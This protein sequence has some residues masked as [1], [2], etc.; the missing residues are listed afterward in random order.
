VSPNSK[1]EDR[2][3]AP[4]G[5][6][7]LRNYFITRTAQVTDPKALPVA[8]TF[9]SK[10]FG[11]NTYGLLRNSLNSLDFKSFICRSYALFFRKSFRYRSYVIKG[12]W[13]GCPLQFYSSKFDFGLRF[14][15]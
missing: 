5:R 11:A 14:R 3:A 6:G 12:G 8:P 13:G 15:P 10:S 4:S 9:P 1:L 2:A 7:V